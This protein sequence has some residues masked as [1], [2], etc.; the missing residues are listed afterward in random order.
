M[1]SEEINTLC[2]SDDTVMVRQG[3]YLSPLLFRIVMDK[4]VSYVNHLQGYRMG[5]E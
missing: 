4:I 5:S 1:G 3:D 2:Y